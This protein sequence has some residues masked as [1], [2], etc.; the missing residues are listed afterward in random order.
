MVK[1]YNVIEETNEGNV[2][3]FN[4]SGQVIIY[5]PDLKKFKFYI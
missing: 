5:L 1:G 2:S 3:L 4:T